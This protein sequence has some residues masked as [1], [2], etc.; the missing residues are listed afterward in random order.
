M[1]PQPSL[2]GRKHGLA[3]YVLDKFKATKRNPL[4]FTSF[5]WDALAVDIKSDFMKKPVTLI[6]LYRLPPYSAALV[7]NF[8]SKLNSILKAMGRPGKYQILAGDTNLNLLRVKEDG[9]ISSFYENLCHQGFSP[10]ITLPSRVTHCSATIIDNIWF[11]SPPNIFTPLQHISSRILTDSISDHFACVTSFNILNPQFEIPRFVTKRNFSDT[12]MQKFASDLSQQDLDQ[13]VQNSLIDEPN[14]TYNLFIEK[15]VK[16]RDQYMPLTKKKFNRKV[17][18]IND[19][20]TPA[21]LKSINTKNK[22]YVAY[23]KIKNN[24]E[25]RTE[26]TVF[27]KSMKAFLTK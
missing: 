4:S 20:I 13:T 25:K 1:I 6:N 24:R 3:I 19:W 22:L 15:I 8:N 26:N 7:E 12:N 11:R 10:H 17:D 23:Q 16:T 2:I 5:I 14:I 21:L 9:P 27:L 18:K